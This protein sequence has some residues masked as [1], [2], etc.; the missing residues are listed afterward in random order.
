MAAD[1]NTFSAGL[2][3]AMAQLEREI[4]PMIRAARGAGSNPERRAA[5]EQGVDVLERLKKS[6]FTEARR[7]ANA[8]RPPAAG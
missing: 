1:D 5:L 7:R 4:P 8:N 6:F 3:W 2:A